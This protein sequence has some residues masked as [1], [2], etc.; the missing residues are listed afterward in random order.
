[1]NIFLNSKSQILTADA[2]LH[3]LLSLEKERWRYRDSDKDGKVEGAQS[4]WES[5]IS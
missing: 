1:M 5:F 2:A 3:E 4:L